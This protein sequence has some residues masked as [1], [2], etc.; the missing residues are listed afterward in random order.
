MPNDRLT[1]LFPQRNFGNLLW[2]IAVTFVLFLSFRL[3]EITIFR[4]T[5]ELSEVWAYSCFNAT[6]R[7]AMQN[8]L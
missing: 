7:F 5:T 1:F 6:T 8:S 3:Q 2:K 4:V